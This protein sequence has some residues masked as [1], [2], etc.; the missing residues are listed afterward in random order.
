MAS[1]SIT[2]TALALGTDRKRLEN[3][4]VRCAVPGTVR[5]RQGRTRRLSRAAVLALALLL[6]LQDRLGV[7]A[8][9]AAELLPALLRSDG[10][11]VEL[12]PVTLSVDLP[13]LERELAAAIAVAVEMAPRPRRGRPPA[14]GRAT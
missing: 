7:P 11:P 14:A 1:Y 2:T 9:F 10:E 6:E 12:G 8:S 3:L 13:R 5:G 4:L